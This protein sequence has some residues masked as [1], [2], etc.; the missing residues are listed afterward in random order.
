MTQPQQPIHDNVGSVLKRVH[1]LGN[2][3]IVQPRVA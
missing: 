1:L 2:R 3:R